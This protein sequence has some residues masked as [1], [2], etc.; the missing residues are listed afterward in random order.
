MLCDVKRDKKLLFTLYHLKWLNDPGYHHI[1][2]SPQCIC[3]G[4]FMYNGNILNTVFPI[5]SW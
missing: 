5:Q 2:K 3:M 1:L 4:Y